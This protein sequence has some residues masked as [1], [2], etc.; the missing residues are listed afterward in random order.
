M[1][2]LEKNVPRENEFAMEVMQ[3]AFPGHV[4]KIMSS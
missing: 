3:E 2:E 4:Q 1:F